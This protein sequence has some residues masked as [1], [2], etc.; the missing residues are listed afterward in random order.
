MFMTGM[1]AVLLTFGLVLAGCPMDE[2]GGGNG[3]GGFIVQTNNSIANDEATLGFVGEYVR[4]S[5]GSV[6]RA[7]IV[8]GKIEITSLSQ[9]DAIITVSGQDY[10]TTIAVMVAANGGITIGAITK[11]GPRQ[12]SITIKSGEYTI[13]GVSVCYWSGDTFQVPVYVL[14]EDYEYGANT[15]INAGEEKTFGPLTIETNNPFDTTYSIGGQVGLSL[16]G[17]SVPVAFA[18]SCDWPEI[19][20]DSYTLIVGTVQYYPDGP[21]YYELREEE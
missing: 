9:G 6:A 21:I 8:G 17:E 2:G 5:N 11:R 1:L 18:V 20:K 4:S 12:V 14:G 7:E 19:P 13:E 16:S 10:G 3:G 15:D